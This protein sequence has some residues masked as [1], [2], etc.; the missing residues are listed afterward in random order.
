[1]NTAEQ[2]K[3]MTLEDYEATSED[4]RIE[5]FEGVPYAMSAPSIQHQD[6]LGELFFLIKD[7]IRNHSGNCKL[8]I[9][10]CDVKLSDNPLTIVQP[11]LFIVCDNNKLDKKGCNGAPEFIIEIVSPSNNSNDYIQKLYYYKHYGAKEYWIVD[12]DRQIITVYNFE[13]NIC[14][15]RYSFD[16]KLKVGIYDDLYIDFAP[17]KELL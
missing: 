14:N 4:E 9:A 12:P 13:N 6:I 8:F 3:L 17:L 2:I 7:Y 15:E 10:P 11:D 5:V 16:D 1:M